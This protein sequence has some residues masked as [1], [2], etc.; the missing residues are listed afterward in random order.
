SGLEIRPVAAV[1]LNNEEADEEGR[2][3]QHQDQGRPD[4]VSQSE[5]DSGDEDEEGRHRAEEVQEAAAAV[6]L[7]VGCNKL[8]PARHAAAGVGIRSGT[9]ARASLFEIAGAPVR[10]A[11]RRFSALAEMRSA[12]VDLRPIHPNHP[13]RLERYTI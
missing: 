4:L 13:Q 9:Q 6:R 5:K 2:S 10:A 3:G 8:A 7:G 11:I 1:V 12:S